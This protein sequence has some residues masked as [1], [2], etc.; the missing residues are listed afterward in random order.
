[1]NTMFDTILQLPLFQG[2]TEDDL[3]HILG[4][5]K[6]HFEKHKPKEVIATANEPC[7]QLLFVLKGTVAANT[8]SANGRINITEYFE[9]PF[10]IEPYSLLGMTPQ[11]VATYTAHTEIHT[12]SLSK[13]F[14]LNELCQYE[15][16]RL[17]LLN[18]ISNRSQTLCRRL[19]DSAT[20]SLENRLIHFIKTHCERL[21]GEKLLKIKM[22]DL[23]LELNDTRT[24][25][26]RILNNLQSNN[27]VDLRR[28]EIL[29]HELEL[30]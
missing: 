16:F 21:T 7:D 30:L 12:L 27:L 23:A 15:I 19:W 26:S 24:S 2:L 22:E 4:K 29:V 8:K 13:S 11:Y 28:G 25:I 5:A 17:N 14:A 9:A 18:I 6:L 1:M 10:L 20:D 3:T